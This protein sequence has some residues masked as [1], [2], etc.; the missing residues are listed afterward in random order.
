MNLQTSVKPPLYRK[1]DRK[2]QKA[3]IKQLNEH[4]TENSLH[5]PLKSA[6]TAN[7]S[8][9]TA[10]LKK[11]LTIFLWHWTNVIVYFLYY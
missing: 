3:A 9:E 8:M 2:L 6:Y 4:L 1:V 5:E 7:H 10:L 11:S